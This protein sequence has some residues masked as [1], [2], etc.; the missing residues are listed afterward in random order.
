M[1]EEGMGIVVG[2]EKSGV[3]IKQALCLSHYSTFKK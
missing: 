3:D 1:I 2:E